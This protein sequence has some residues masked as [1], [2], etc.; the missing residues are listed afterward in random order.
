MDERS[1]ALAWQR[2]LVAS[3]QACVQGLEPSCLACYTTLDRQFPLI[4]ILGQS[5]RTN[6]HRR[7]PSS[8]AL[9]NDGEQARLLQQVRNAAKSLR[10]GIGHSYEPRKLSEMVARGAACA[11][12][13]NSCVSAEG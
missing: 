9:D 1:D 7:E 5:S 13:I 11:S 12:V 10:A 3:T 8:R 2:R 4:S 6:R